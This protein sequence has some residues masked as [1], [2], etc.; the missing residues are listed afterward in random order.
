MDLFR[1]VRRAAQRFETRREVSD[2]RV[3]ATWE[4][5]FELFEDELDGGWV[6]RSIDLPGCFTQGDTQEEAVE[7]MGSAVEAWLIA[8][9]DTDLGLTDAEDHPTPAP[10]VAV[11]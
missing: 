7:A 6:A 3:R 10:Q 1:L 5:E 9:I 11:I 8:R 2:H 4:F